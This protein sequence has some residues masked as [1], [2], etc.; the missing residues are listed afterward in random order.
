[1]ILG[2][3]A[4]E[5][6]FIKDRSYLWLNMLPNPNRSHAKTGKPCYYRKLPTGIKQGIYNIL[7]GIDKSHPLVKNA[8][9]KGKSAPFVLFHCLV[10]DFILVLEQYGCT[11]YKQ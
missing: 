10:P 1:M 5:S 11:V 4:V 7:R 9:K 8:F 3:S 2:G 6:F